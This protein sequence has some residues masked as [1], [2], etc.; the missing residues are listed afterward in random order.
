GGQRPARD[1]APRRAAQNMQ[2]GHA[3][4][5]LQADK[6]E[7]QQGDRHPQATAQQYD[8][9]DRQNDGYECRGHWPAIWLSISGLSVAGIAVMLWAVRRTVHNRDS[10][11]D[12]K[13]TPM[14]N[15][16]LL[17]GTQTGM[18]SRPMDSVFRR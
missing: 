11:N 15:N 10:I 1:R 6:A 4:K 3:G 16:M 12:R 5:K 18:A 9:G 2:T 13:S 7:R 14:P 8:E 17:C